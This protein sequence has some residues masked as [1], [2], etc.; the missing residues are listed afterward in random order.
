MGRADPGGEI[1]LLTTRGRR[2]GR[3][4]TNPLMFARDGESFVVIASNAG[5]QRHPGWYWNV[6][7]SPEVSREIPLVYLDRR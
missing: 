6:T 1:L 4:R 5:R 2:S 7:S 3:A